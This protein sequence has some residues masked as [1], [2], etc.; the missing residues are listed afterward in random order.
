MFSVTLFATVMHG[1]AY[2]V[3]VFVKSV[4]IYLLPCL[5]FVLMHIFIKGKT[6]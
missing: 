6:V 1:R 5:S 4:Y 2:T 3:E